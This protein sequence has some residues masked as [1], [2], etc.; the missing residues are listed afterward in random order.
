MSEALW[1]VPAGLGDRGSEAARVIVEFLKERGLTDH[2]GGGA[3][4]SP[5]EWAERGEEYGKSSVLVVVHDGGAHAPAF[6]W[7]YG[8]YG[9]IEDLDARLRE[10]GLFPEQCTS[11]YSAVY[12]INPPRKG[13][14]A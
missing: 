8:D 12:E 7:D 5:Q 3:F 1:P 10:H 9:L 4:R 14:N 13:E 6:N 11:W 2:G